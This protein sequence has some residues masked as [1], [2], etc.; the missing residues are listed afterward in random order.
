VAGRWPGWTPLSHRCGQRRSHRPGPPQGHRTRAIRD[1]LIAAPQPEPEV[2]QKTTIGDAI[3]EYLRY[4]KMQRKPRTYLTYRYTLDV[5]LRA[6]YKRKYI[7]DATRKDVLDFMTYC[8]EQKLG[9]RTVYDKVVTVLQLFKKHGRTGSWR[10]AIGRSTSMP[11][12]RS[13][14]P[15]N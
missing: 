12:D 2:A 13:M 5:L 9:A 8:Y 14:S 4:V 3:D 6:S 10:R 11:F 1:G 15:K 7:E